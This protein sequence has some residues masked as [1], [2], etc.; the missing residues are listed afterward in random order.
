MKQWAALTKYGV[1]GEFDR[2]EVT[3]STK[4]KGD[5]RRLQPLFGD[6]KDTPREVPEGALAA[7]N[8]L[9]EDAAKVKDEEAFTAFTPASEQMLLA[10]ELMFLRDLHARDLRH[11]A[12][13]AWITGFA[14]CPSMVWS[15][16][17]GLARC[18][19]SCARAIA[20]RPC[21]LLSRLPQECGEKPGRASRS[22][23]N[24]LRRLGSRSAPSDVEVS[25]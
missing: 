24:Y 4:L 18:R 10:A 7:R 8:K 21:G 6:P 14:S 17:G 19:T 16:S 3:P 13:G 25:A 22:C 9:L 20:R 1:I 5:A 2:E 12:G 11:K 23:G 15:V